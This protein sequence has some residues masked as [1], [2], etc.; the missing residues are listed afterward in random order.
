MLGLS[1]GLTRHSSSYIVTCST[2]LVVFLLFFPTHAVAQK[3]EFSQPESFINVPIE[4]RYQTLQNKLNQSLPETL[5]N[6][7]DK[8]RVCVK[9]RFGKIRCDVKGWVKRNGAIGVSAKQKWLEFTVPIKAKVSAKAG[10]RETVEA[11]ATLIIKA[12]PQIKPDWT[13]ALQ[14][15]PDYRWDKEPSI[16]LFDIVSINLARFVE[17]QIAKQ[18]D[19]F[20]KKVPHMLS[21]LEVKKKMA[22]VWRKLHEPK[23]INKDL[24]A[25]LYFS[26]KHVAFTGLNI[27][28]QALNTTVY[29]AGNTSIEVS[30]KRKI[31]A[32]SLPVLNTQTQAPSQGQF[33]INLPITLS[34]QEISHSFATKLEQDNQKKQKELTLLNPELRGDNKG[35]IFLDIDIK[36]ANQN[37][38]LQFF[39]ITDW[40][41]VNGRL[42]F[43]G[44]PILDKDS[45]TLSI[46]NLEYVANTNSGIV[47]GAI[48]L[49]GLEMIRQRIEDK[50]HFP[51]AE[52]I[53][54]AIAK[55]NLSLQQQ[56]TKG[57]AVNAALTKVSLNS[58]KVKQSTIDL[59][60]HIA[61]NVSVS[62]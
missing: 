32:S 62:F 20:V 41:S 1:N 10:I 2:L 55:A 17:P 29:I 36:Y 53:D 45:Q 39:N 42:A 61:G 7:Y 11:A 22:S 35:E 6:I 14:V 37:A 57:I 16:E 52:K 30:N 26:P 12:K 48:D 34:L 54:T 18:M 47:D 38:V 59:T 21:Q 19:K 46:S 8:N 9:T 23:Q 4:I 27:G 49:A 50:A 33:N 31:S 13:L 25:Y 15:F 43:S 60:T 51:L 28:Q 3:S 40:F 56:K 44:T 5:A 58:L 24:D